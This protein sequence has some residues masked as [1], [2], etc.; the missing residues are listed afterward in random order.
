[1]RFLHWGTVISNITKPYVHTVLTFCNDLKFLYT[2]TNT[3]MRWVVGLSLCKRKS[4]KP[5]NKQTME[6]IL[7]HGFYLFL[8]WCQKD[9]FY[10]L[11]YQGGGEPSFNLLKN[12]KG[13][14]QNMVSRRKVWNALRERF[15]CYVSLLLKFLLLN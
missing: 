7:E 15:G 12:K 6:V 13:N 11:R 1:M 5:V 4:V 3:I 2:N 9:C 8:L 10:S 14:S